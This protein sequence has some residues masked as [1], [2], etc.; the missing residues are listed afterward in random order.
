[1]WKLT[2]TNAQMGFQKLCE[3]AGASKD[4]IPSVSNVIKEQL[5]HNY[6]D[7]YEPEMLEAFRAMGDVQANNFL[8][9]IHNIP[10]RH[11][12]DT[13]NGKIKEYLASSGTTGIAGAVYLIPVK[14]YADLQTEAVQADVVAQISKVL[15][16]PDQV[17]PGTTM[18]VD[19]AKDGQY[20]V[21][22]I[23]GGAIAPSESMETV[24]ATLD[25][26]PIYGINIRLANDLLEDS[27]F[28]ILGLHTSEAGRQIGE[29][30][31]DLAIT[32]MY[33][34]TDGDGTRN[35]ITGDQAYA[36]WAADGS[37][38]VED[39][40]SLNLSDGY[41]PDTMLLTHK[42]YNY[43]LKGTSGIQYNESALQ[44]AWLQSGYPTQLAGMN[45]VYSDTDYLSNNQAY[46]TSKMI[47]FTKAYALLS[48]RKRWMRIENYSEPV[49]DLKGAMITFRQDS[50][51]LYNDSIAPCIEGS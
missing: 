8:A 46:D 51:T 49:R 4:N 18:K 12:F 44:A 9:S 19:I 40:I 31:S 34:S 24:Q 28:D 3:T 48:G 17:S 20:K 47:V 33:L 5:D 7:M 13:R 43:N 11:F 16:G 2:E 30:A 35:L 38:T 1:M 22:Q 21:S 25:F 42:A 10:F 26:T 50:V 27:Q 39:G 41:V 32:V 6:F 45:L 37:H 15:L 36:E 29:K 23:A 14:L